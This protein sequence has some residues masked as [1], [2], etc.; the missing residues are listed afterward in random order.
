MLVAF[1]AWSLGMIVT[2]AWLRGKVVG[3]NV[4][5]ALLRPPATSRTGQMTRAEFRE[6]L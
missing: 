5:S 2:G 1:L 3:W 4:G 6:K